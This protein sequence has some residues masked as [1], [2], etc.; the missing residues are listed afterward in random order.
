VRGAGS[1]ASCAARSLGANFGACLAGQAVSC[2]RQPPTRAAAV[3][4]FSECRLWSFGVIEQLK[5][6][7]LVKTLA[8]GDARRRA[9]KL[10][11]E[12]ATKLAGLKHKD[13]GETTD[14]DGDE[15]NAGV[16]RASPA[17]PAAAAATASDAGRQAAAEQTLEFG[18]EVSSVQVGCTLTC[19]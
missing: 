10:L 11:R 16:D 5:L 7:R 9:A 12:V 3:R 8:D 2:R 1:R 13:E 19:V 6:G 4:A 18:D 14:E 17:A 15:S